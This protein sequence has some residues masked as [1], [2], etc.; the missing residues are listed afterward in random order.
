MS[1][2]VATHTTVLGLVVE[3]TVYIMCHLFW[4]FLFHCIIPD[5][6]CFEPISCP[7]DYWLLMIP[8]AYI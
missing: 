4:S 3:D 8:S 2:Y 5:S 6:A 1:T 7:V